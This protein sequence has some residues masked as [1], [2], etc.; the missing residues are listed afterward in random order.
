VKLLLQNKTP[1]VEVNPKGGI[2]YDALRAAT[3][4]GN[5]AIVRLLIESGADVNA[6]GP[7]EEASRLGYMAIVKLLLQNGADVNGK[8]NPL[9]AAAGRGREAIVAL[10]LEK[11]AN[12]NAPGSNVLQVA[13]NHGHEA[14]VR[15][16]LKNG[17]DVNAP[18]VYYRDN[19]MDMFAL[20][21]AASR[22]HVAVA[23]LLLEEGADVNA[24]G[25]S[26]GNALGAARTGRIL[27]EVVVLS[28]DGSTDNT[29]RVPAVEKRENMVRLLLE[30]GATE[31][32]VR[33]V[34]GQAE[35]C[36]LRDE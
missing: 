16:L 28:E 14:T 32:P 23:R 13:C 10:L 7:L 22:G 4:A 11:G 1:K 20:Q 2:E 15:L 26:T 30:W 31:T 36:G 19:C 33:Q 34:N 6:N 3:R 25:G 21:T 18:R 29:P 8:G 24:E 9:Q 12:V 35:G 27:E 17:A 5:E